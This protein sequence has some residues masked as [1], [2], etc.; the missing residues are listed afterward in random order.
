MLPIRGTSPQE[1]SVRFRLYTQEEGRSDL[2]L[3]AT[4]IENSE[5]ELMAVE[6][7]NIIVA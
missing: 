6:V 1:Y 3:Q 5:D 2:E 7:D 4:F